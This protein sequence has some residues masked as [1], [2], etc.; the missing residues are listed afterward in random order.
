MNSV[1]RFNSPARPL[2]RCQRIE[3]QNPNH[4]ISAGFKPLVDSASN[5]SEYSVSFGGTVWRNTV[6]GEPRLVETREFTYKLAKEY[7]KTG[8]G[9]TFMEIM[10]I[11]LPIQTEYL[12]SVKLGT[13][14]HDLSELGKLLVKGLNL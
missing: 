5:S 7:E 11:F 8:L 9:K 13:V 4:V 6:T 3:F 12:N 1:N 10:R 14:P 2:R